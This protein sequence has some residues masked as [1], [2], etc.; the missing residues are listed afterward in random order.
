M[1]VNLSKVSEQPDVSSRCLVDVC[2][3][4]IQQGTTVRSVPR[5]SMTVP[6]ALPMEAVGSRIHARVSDH[7]QGRK[8]VR[9]VGYHLILIDKAGVEIIKLRSIWHNLL[10]Y[11]I[12][13]YV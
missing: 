8:S 13:Q 6:G 5:S 3:L 10:T 4:T 1:S 7:Q 11:I 2:V 12:D 9:S